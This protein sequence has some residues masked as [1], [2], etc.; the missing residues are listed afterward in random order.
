MPTFFQLVS[1][2]V[3]CKYGLKICRISKL[4]AFQKRTCI[5]AR[6]ILLLRIEKIQEH[7][8]QILTALL[9]VDGR[10]M[11]VLSAEYRHT[12]KTWINIHFYVDICRETLIDIFAISGIKS[13][14]EISDKTGI[15][16]WN[17]LKCVWTTALL[18]WLFLPNSCLS[19]CVCLSHEDMLPQT[20]LLLWLGQT[21][22]KFNS[23]TKWQRKSSEMLHPLKTIP[24]SY[25]LL[26]KRVPLGYL[27]ICTPLKWHVLKKRFLKSKRWR[28][29]SCVKCGLVWSFIY[30]EK[31]CFW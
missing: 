18:F 13:K 27:N 25:W 28:R 16:S 6:P 24:N 31:W 1:M 10:E 14:C 21:A 12:N 22:I 20:F 15:N 7:L 4:L 29:K 26:G 5:S 19:L 2:W 30:T 8:T 9:F 3:L 17:E 23:A 11:H